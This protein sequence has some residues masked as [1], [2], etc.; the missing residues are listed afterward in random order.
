MKT[1]S[2]KTVFENEDGDRLAARL[3]FLHIRSG[4]FVKFF[5]HLE[6]RFRMPVL[7]T[8]VVEISER[9]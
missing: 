7:R 1:I 5:Q 6:K 3:D 4:G 9:A 2:K 8:R